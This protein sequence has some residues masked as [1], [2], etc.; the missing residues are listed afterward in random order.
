[1]ADEQ[2]DRVQYAFVLGWHVAEL[3]HYKNLGSN[4]SSGNAIP[5][6]L[7]GISSLSPIERSVLLATQIE[8]DV[9][10]TCK[11]DC[12]DAS[13]AVKEVQDALKQDKPSK[14]E[15]QGKLLNLH[16]SLLTSLMAPDFRCG[17]AY[18]LGRALAETAML[19]DQEDKDSYKKSFDVYRVR[20]LQEWLT[21]LRSSFPP[22]ASHAIVVALDRWVAWVADYVNDPAAAAKLKKADPDETLHRQGQLWRAL[23]SGEKSGTEFLSPD[24]YLNAAQNL[25]SNARKIVWSVM[26]R[27]VGLGF[28][29]LLLVTVLLLI[30][31]LLGQATAVTVAFLALLGALG[32]TGKTVIDFANKAWSIAEEPLWGSEMAES[33][34]GAACLLP[35][36]RS[37]D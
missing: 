37:N 35:K 23:L 31:V 22:Y 10:T 30:L 15:I 9:Q 20:E 27:W 11:F 7:P 17:K 13:N 14:E 8:S 24:D 28:L 21:D 18:G 36:P 2:K 1:M 32:I 19:P 16:K 5:P 26:N 33:V 25:L 4:S 12:A 3:Y 29:V 34:A 6:A